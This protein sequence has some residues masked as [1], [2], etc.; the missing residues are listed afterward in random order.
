MGPGLPAPR[1][2]ELI[3]RNDGRTVRRLADP[4]GGRPTL[5]V[6]RFERRRAALAEREAARLHALAARGLR[7]PPLLARA[8][9]ADGAVLL[10][11]GELAGTPLDEWLRDAG[12]K[13]RRA[14]ADPL[15]AA[16]ATL[17]RCGAAHRQLFAWHVVIG[18]AETADATAAFGLLDVAG[19]QLR[20]P[21]QRPS[22][23]ERAFDLAAL[24]ATLP[25]SWFSLA[26]RARLLRTYEPDR[27]ARRALVPRLRRA[28]A[29]L[30]RRARVP[31]D[32]AHREWRS[33]TQRLLVAEPVARSCGGNAESAWSDVR[34]WLA[35]DGATVVRTR[36]GRS[37]LD[38]RSPFG[39]DGSRW[40][41]KRF[42]RAP[43]RGRTFAFQ[44]FVTLRALA[45]IGIPTPAIVAVGR[46]EGAA[47]ARSILWT[48]G[49]Q[50]GT[51]LRELLPQLAP[52]RSRASE[53]RRLL[54]EAGAIARRL[55]AAGFC[56]RDL[57]LDH[58]LVEEREGRRRLVL[59]DATRVVGFARLPARARTKDLAALEFSARSAG[60]S[61]AERWRALV[62]Y[63]RRDRRLARRLAR[64]ALRK[65]DRIARRERR[66]GRPGPG[67]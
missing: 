25:R 60:A 23:V 9:D 67:A 18:P 33:A 65:A 38:W 34:T 59:I 19:A 28:R 14:A 62:E 2:G 63:A 26:D 57:Y 52:P 17:H 61:R 3:G 27:T 53:R 41:G 32:W 66:N 47:P 50:P 40:F 46:N 37:N 49:V 42:E 45:A 31:R 43:W 7:V 29:R 21:G 39:A 30:V 4:T 58:F 5:F 13:S 15:G 54:L 56:H 44:E 24:F 6:K 8:T 48:R 11:L 22:A 51:T 64:A 16:I 10:V 36:D 55:H 20:E 35:P 12:P 1:S